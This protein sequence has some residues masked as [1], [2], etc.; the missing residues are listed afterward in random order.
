MLKTIFTADLLNA[1]VEQIK[2]KNDN[3]GNRIA[4][5][6]SNCGT[7]S[8]REDFVKQLQQF[9]GVDVFGNCG[10]LQV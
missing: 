2:D 7:H 10:N 9:M 3:S 5:M 6:V 1:I 4:W 8:R